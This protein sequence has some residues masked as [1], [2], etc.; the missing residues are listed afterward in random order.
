MPIKVESDVQQDTA[1]ASTEDDEVALPTPIYAPCKIIAADG[2][3]ETIDRPIAGFEHLFQASNQIQGTPCSEI[4]APTGRVTSRT[5]QRPLPCTTSNSVVPCTKPSSPIGANTTLRSRD[6]FSR[7]ED[8]STT[9]EE[10]FTSVLH[11]E[12]LL[13]TKNH[14]EK[15]CRGKVPNKS[16]SIAV[17]SACPSDNDEESE[18]EQCPVTTVIPR[19]FRM[20]DFKELKTFLCNRMDELTMK[21]FR[22]IVTMWIKLLEPKR[23]RDYGSYHKRMPFEKPE[24]TTPPW[25][26]RDCHYNEPSHL[27]KSGIHPEQCDMNAVVNVF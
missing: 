19:S 11:S 13:W 25:W 22:P 7:H 26:P 21:P 23:L 3:V 4:P 14:P 24:D 27:S 1:K 9:R 10:N 18:S 15:R 17:V 6:T 20:G 5:R 12:S 16:R 8:S 2:R